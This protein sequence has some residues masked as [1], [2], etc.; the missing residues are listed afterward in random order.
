MKGRRA[1]LEHWTHGATQVI[2]ALCLGSG[3][4]VLRWTTSTVSLWCSGSRLE[5]IGQVFFSLQVVYLPASRRH[6]FLLVKYV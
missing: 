4:L 6:V 2:L 1:A 3:L 5:M